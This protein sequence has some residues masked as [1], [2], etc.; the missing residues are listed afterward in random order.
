VLL[1]IKASYSFSM[2]QH[3]DGSVRAA[4]MEVGTTDCGDDEV[5]DNVNLSVGIWKPASPARSLD[6]G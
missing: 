5:A 3:K 1:V 2:A 4:W 6:E